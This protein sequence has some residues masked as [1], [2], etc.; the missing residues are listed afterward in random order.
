MSGR[1]KTKDKKVSVP[2]GTVRPGTQTDK[3]THTFLNMPLFYFEYKKSTVI[4][5][6][7][8]PWE[9]LTEAVVADSSEILGREKCTTQPALNADSN[10]K[11]R[12]SPHLEK[13]CSARTAMR[14]GKDSNNHRF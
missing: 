3:I 7:G 8:K 14:K 13:K 10:V 4:S 2:R 12:S 1:N 9:I 6:G 11:S 5:I